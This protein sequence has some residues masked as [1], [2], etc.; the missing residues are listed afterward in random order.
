MAFA[1]GIRN[2]YAVGLAASWQEWARLSS[3][4]SVTAYTQGPWWSGYDV[5]LHESSRS[6]YIPSREFWN[7]RF[8]HG[9]NAYAVGLAASWEE[10]ARLSSYRSATAYPPAT[11]VDRICCGTARK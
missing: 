9:Q 2:P 8:V 10:W 5:A 4:R 3:Y 7:I 1:A 6:K 11:L